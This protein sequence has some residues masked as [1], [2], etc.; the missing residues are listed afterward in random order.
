M[1][2]LRNN[3][4]E[5]EIMKQ[6][7]TFVSFKSLSDGVNITTAF[8]SKEAYDVN[9]VYLGALIGPLAG[10]TS[11]NRYGS[12][13]DVNNPPNHL[14]GGKNG[15][16]LKVFDVEQTDT[17]AIFTLNDDGVYY[18][19][20][21]SLEDD[22]LLLDMK[23]T[24]SQARRLNL[25]NHMYFNLL[26]EENLDN[27]Q[28]ELIA[29]KV[30]YVT[31]DILNV[32]NLVAVKDTAFDLNKKTSVKDILSRTNEQFEITRHI[33]HSYLAN[34]VRLFA[35][36]KTLSIEA[37]APAMHLYFGNYLEGSGIDS[38]GRDIQNHQS[39]AIEPQYFP[40]DID[41]PEYTKD[42][43]FHETIKYTY[44]IK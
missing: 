21:V 25:T 13:L 3:K 39:L 5:V 30:S 19:I 26:N 35:K 32:G 8:N 38:K 1:I 24:P 22:T 20:N 4:L 16:H 9:G 36:N 7:V 28:V 2:T 44:T 17:K 31:E 14:H 6:G 37:T 33:D 23:A 40:N 43:P 34:K 29:E 18:E 42:K 27:H 10:R 12:N 11:P 15:L 41:L